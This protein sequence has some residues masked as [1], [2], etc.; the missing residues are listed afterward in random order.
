MLLRTVTMSDNCRHTDIRAFDNVRCC[1]SCGFAIV[2]EDEIPAAISEANNDFGLLSRASRRP[3]VHKRLNHHLGKQVR[4][5]IIESAAYEAEL[6]C[7]ILHVNLDDRPQFY[8]VSYTWGDQHGEASLSH[9]VVC[10]D[11]TYIKISA[12][13]DRVLRRIRANSA[14]KA[15]WID[16]ICIDQNHVLERNHQVGMMDVI[17]SQ[18]QLVVIDVGDGT[19]ASEELVRLIKEGFS[20][21]ALRKKQ[22]IHDF[23]Q[24]RWFTRMW[25]LQEVA[26]ARYAMVQCGNQMI[27]WSTLKEFLLHAVPESNVPAALKIKVGQDKLMDFSELVSTLNESRACDVEDPRD[28]VYALLGLCQPRVREQIPVDYALTISELTLAVTIARLCGSSNDKTAI[29]RQVMRYSASTRT[30]SEPNWPELASTAFLQFQLSARLINNFHARTR[31]SSEELPIHKIGVL[32]KG[33]FETSGHWLGNVLFASNISEVL[34]MN[35]IT[36]E[37]VPCDPKGSV[38]WASKGGDITMAD[39]LGSII[40]SNFHE[41][42]PQQAFSLGQDSAKNASLQDWLA[43]KPAWKARKPAWKAREISLHHFL[44][45][46]NANA[47]GVKIFGTMDYLGYGPTSLLPGDSI[48]CL[49]GQPTCLILRLSHDYITQEAL[50]AQAWKGLKERRSRSA[51]DYLRWLDDTCRGRSPPIPQYQ[52]I[53]ECD[54]WGA[55]IDACEGALK[56]LMLCLPARI[57]LNGSSP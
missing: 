48:W 4:L 12:N 54:Y 43:W 55:D 29:L 17:Y 11:G 36:T 14:Q 49:K 9:C 6:R 42:Q 18:A 1:M 8:A 47:S 44:S 28:Q 13:C 27:A 45:S 3:Y 41:P 19:R 34:V 10:H 38:P 2:E 25:V 30:G 52:L 20:K 51:S 23:L 46:V 33:V 24:Q 5:V 22:A 7:R 16:M 32:D 31:P 40:K 53:G 57:D 35:N 15:L 50:L 21:K 37:S 39:Y 26:L 56:K